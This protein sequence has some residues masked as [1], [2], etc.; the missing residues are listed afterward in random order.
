MTTAEA[1]NEY[2]YR[3]GYDYNLL[4]EVADYEAEQEAEAETAECWE[5]SGKREM[6]QTLFGEWEV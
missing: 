6:N 5:R 1:A 2:A 3:N 4:S